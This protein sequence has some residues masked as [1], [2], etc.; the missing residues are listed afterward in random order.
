MKGDEEKVKEKS[1]KEKVR[2]IKIIGG[3]VYDSPK[4]RENIRRRMARTREE[5][6]REIGERS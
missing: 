1:R 4:I 5:I 2:K 6:E 3:V